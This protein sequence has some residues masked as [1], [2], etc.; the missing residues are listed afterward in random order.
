MHR[1]VRVVPA[2][3]PESVIL[4]PAATARPVDLLVASGYAVVVVA[5]VTEH[6]WL[7]LGPHHARPNGLRVPA[8][9]ALGA[10]LVS[11]PFASA[12]MVL[13]QVAEDRAPEALASLTASHPLV[14][15]VVAFVAWDAAGFAH[16]WLGH[17]S[18]IGWASHQVHHSGAGYDLSL[19]W[20]QSWLPV[21]ALV[22]FPFVA[23]TGVGLGTAVVCAALSNTWQALA[24]TAICSGRALGPLGAVI[25]VPATHRIHHEAR[26]PI[27]LGPV[28]TVWDR[29]AGTWVPETTPGSSTSGGLQARGAVSIEAAG[30]VDLLSRS[31]RSFRH[32][33]REV[34]RFALGPLVGLDYVD[35]NRPNHGG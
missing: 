19:A 29:L 1:V 25:V 7:R 22:T 14:G 15:F 4:E 32:H 5:V 12:Q 6:L 28:L 13:W 35:S 9:M 34:S 17:H 8:A 10:V 27:N 26:R 11:I 30:W 24:H 2:T 16:H 31:V 3:D 18:A 20:R 23:L 33:R 21:T